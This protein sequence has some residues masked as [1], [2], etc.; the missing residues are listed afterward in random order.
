MNC[1]AERGAGGS[2]GSC[3][4]DA[5]A[6]EAPVERD[7]FGKCVAKTWV[8]DGRRSIFRFMSDDVYRS[9]SL[10]GGL[11]AASDAARF[12]GHDGRRR[13]HTLAAMDVSSHGT[14]SNCCMAPHAHP[15]SMSCRGGLQAG[16]G[17]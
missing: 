10:E 13:E 14:L 6:E 7:V 3:A 12:A 15:L 1:S 4:E 17:L 5:V 2:C 11:A 8:Q 9:S 16:A